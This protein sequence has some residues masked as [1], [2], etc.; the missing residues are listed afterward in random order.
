MNEQ[1]R[2]RF[3]LEGRAWRKGHGSTLYGADVEMW[4]DAPY[5]HLVAIHVERGS[6]T[7]EGEFDRLLEDVIAAPSAKWNVHVD[8]DRGLVCLI[9]DVTAAPPLGEPEPT[10]D[11]EVARITTAFCDE[12]MTLVTKGTDGSL[13]MAGLM[14]VSTVVGL[15]DA[16]TSIG[17]T[18]KPSGCLVASVHRQ[19][20]EMRLVFEKDGTIMNADTLEKMDVGVA[21]DAVKAFVSR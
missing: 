21:R 19:A 2:T 1:A 8:P 9:Q 4:V 7:S 13:R 12:V 11:P 14:L 10:I 6:R 15:L 5:P 3:L 20:R 16:R 17:V 18:L